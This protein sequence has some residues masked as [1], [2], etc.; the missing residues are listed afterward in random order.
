MLSLCWS[1]EQPLLCSLPTVV[2]TPPPG[3]PSWMGNREQ[4]RE[5]TLEIPKGGQG[6]TKVCSKVGVMET[7]EDLQS[8]VYIPFDA[9]QGGRQVAGP[10]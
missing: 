9:A 6:I 1:Q 7:R 10:P 8:G 2:T 3:W 4:R 5:L